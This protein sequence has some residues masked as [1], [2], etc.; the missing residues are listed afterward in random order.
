MLF[1]YTDGLPEATDRKEEMFGSVRMLETLNRYRKEA[2][3]EL[4]IGIRD[5]VGEFVGE[6]EPFDDLTMMA[7]EWGKAE[8]K[9]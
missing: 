4:L 7:L 1:V 8:K 6:R 2:P 3:K 9:A 5:T